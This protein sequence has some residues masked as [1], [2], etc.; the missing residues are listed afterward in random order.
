MSISV[1]PVQGSVLPVRAGDGVEVQFTCE[2]QEQKVVS[3][4]AEIE[5]LGAWTAE[6]TKR[7]PVPPFE[8]GKLLVAIL[9]SIEAEEGDYP[10]SI[11]L[12]CDGDPVET[13]GTKELVL[14]VS[15]APARP[16][17][18]PVILPPPS[19][20]EP[21]AAP[22]PPKQQEAPRLKQEVKKDRLETE[23][24][25]N[26]TPEAKPPEA[27]KPESPATKKEATP[28]ET[29]KKRKLFVDELQIEAPL[30]PPVEVPIVA[31]APPAVNTPES[32]PEPV[33]EPEPV[34]QPEPL[35]EKQPEPEPIV[36]REPIPEPVIESEP[37][38]VVARA[39]EPEPDLE[40]VF[41]P[42][43]E[44]IFAPEPEPVFAPKP[45]WRPEPE[46]EPELEP[47]PEPIPE[48]R[49]Q[50]KPV[51]KPEPRVITFEEKPRAEEAE[52]DPTIDFAANTVIANPTDGTTLYVKPGETLLVRI[53]ISNDQDGVRTYV[54]QEDRTL[55]TDWIALVRDQVNITPNGT[56][57][58]AFSLKPP[59]SAEPA[60]YPFTVSYGILGKTLVPCY[61]VL[62]VQAMPAVRI[63]TKAK[64]VRV[65]PFGNTVPFDLT[66]ATAGNADTAYR[67]AVL[68]DAAPDAQDQRPVEVYETTSWRYLFDK[69]EESLASP[70]AGRTPPPMPHR[71]SVTRKGIWWLGWMERHKLRV[72]AMPVTDQTNGGKTGN[73]I[74]LIAGRWRLL[75]LPWFIFFPLLLLAIVL[76]GSGGDNFRV[77]N[78][79]KGDD[80]TYYVPGTSMNG[81]TLPVNL[82]WSAP[83]YAL[84]KLGRVSKEGLVAIPKHGVKTADSIQVLGYGQ[85]QQFTYE[86]ASKVSSSAVKTSV[87][88][89]PMKTDHKLEVLGSSQPSTDAPEQIGDEHVQVSGRTITVDVPPKGV[90]LTFKNHTN[91][92]GVL[93]QDIYLWTVHM[94]SGFEVTDFQG[95]LGNSQDINGG[96]Y[97]TARIKTTSDSPT[98]SEWDLLTTDSGCQIL[99]VKLRAVPQ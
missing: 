47:E 14:R 16:V 90:V 38:P 81:S 15:P 54:L 18:V 21:L 91:E 95:N 4:S 37:E 98:D 55:P 43:P 65:G 31:A 48:P 36:E 59:S 50:P 84:L 99:H 60:T 72:S 9:P 97:H 56:G 3:F 93:G 41:A 52:V 11:K 13:D 96:T 34:P 69:E 42:E 64:S 85:A 73:T 7:L 23:S 1:D 45:E 75:P 40:P 32:K 76:L 46:P 8:S 80:G 6:K 12:F 89:V 62:A 30:P 70:A 44:P 35:A 39:P 20:V 67:I 5:G 94:P 78:G 79:F 88:L 86:L 92:G 19:I 28:P 58:L 49:P 71:L 2:N 22:E 63:E 77:T 10:F 57:D 33:R 26:A 25:A 27:K 74:D 82:A 61:L 87:Q 29:P 17:E 83:P 53:S 51:S 24:K 66:V 68:E